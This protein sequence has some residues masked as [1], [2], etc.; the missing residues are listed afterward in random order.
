MEIHDKKQILIFSRFRRH[1][2]P[3]RETKANLASAVDI[4]GLNHPKSQQTVR[5]HETNVH[6]ATDHTIT[7]NTKTSQNFKLLSVVVE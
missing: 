4:A 2:A 7:R 6:N 1:F 5:G 3:S